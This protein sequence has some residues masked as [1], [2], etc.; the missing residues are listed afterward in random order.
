[1]AKYPQV[2]KLS[3]SNAFA[4][5]TLVF[6]HR[7]VVS[8]FS[9][10]GV[11]SVATEEAVMRYISALTPAHLFLRHYLSRGNQYNAYSAPILLRHNTHTYWEI[12][13]VR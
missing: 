3:S 1:M 12:K 13:L 7:G 6:K 8:F 4:R 10:R 11:V 2:I 9:S 5:P